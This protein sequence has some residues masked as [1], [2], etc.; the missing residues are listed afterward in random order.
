M[1][2]IAAAFAAHAHRFQKRKGDGSAYICHPLRMAAAL[3]AAG[4]DETTIIGALLHD[5][6][7]DTDVTPEQ[8]RA[9]FG[10]HVA[11]MVAELTDD[12]ELSKEF[13]K[14]LCVT[15]APELSGGAAL[16]KLADCLDNRASMNPVPQGW[17][18]ERRD[19][20]WAW[21]E[22]VIRAVLT[23]PRCTG[24]ADVA[25]C[26]FHAS[27]DPLRGAFMGAI[28][29]R[30]GE[31]EAP[32]SPEAL[33]AGLVQLN[34][35]RVESLDH[36][37]SPEG[38]L[39]EI[40]SSLPGILRVAAEGARHGHTRLT[41]STSLSHEYST[42]SWDNE[43]RELQLRAPFSSRTVGACAGIRDALAKFIT[44]EYGL[45]TR[46]CANSITIYFS[47]VPHPLGI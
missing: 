40:R 11:G 29:R 44:D 37:A 42:I 14:E 7:E 4:A 1:P 35:E 16:V 21:T 24:W 22:R 19:E 47:G 5:T 41:I 30:R 10:E 32:L 33:R 31:V 2:I 12:K 15:H 45:E 18:D 20:Y 26:L 17:S 9:E 34:A 38:V 46:R 3:K 23:T 39:H 36:A 8:L 43:R 13:R 28:Q 27:I 25:H 6:V